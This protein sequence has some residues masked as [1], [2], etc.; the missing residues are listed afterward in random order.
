MAENVRVKA[1]VSGRVQGVNFRDFTLRQALGL[2]V[3]GYVKNL[4]GGTVEVWAE[5]KRPALEML[6]Q[7]LEKG[8]PQASVQVVDVNWGQASGNL[9]GFSIRY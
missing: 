2:N 8:P 1:V 5:G 4:P 7:R 9:N 6:I 3:T